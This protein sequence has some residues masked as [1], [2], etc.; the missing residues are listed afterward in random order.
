VR[1]GAAGPRGAAARHRHALA[2]G[3]KLLWYH[4]ERVLGHGAFG[5]TYLAQDENLHRPVAIKEF[6]PGQLA[7][8]EDDGS[9]QPLSEEFADDY[10]AGLASF[11]SEA[12]TLAQLEHPSIVRVHNVFEANETAYLVMQYEDGE[13]LDRIL[14]RKRTLDETEI[15]RLLGPLLAGLEYMHARGFVHRDIKPANVFIRRDG[16]PVLLDFGSARQAVS[17]EAR[18][19]TNFVSPGYAPIE[20]YAGKSDQQGPWSDIY[21]LGATL[22]RA[23]TG[24][25][26]PDAVSRSHA[27]AEDTSDSYT[28]TTNRVEGTYSPALLHAVDRALQFRVQDRPQDIGVWRQELPPLTQ[29]PADLAVRVIEDQPT[30]VL[31]RRAGA[32]PQT[33]EVVAPFGVRA[34]TLWLGGALAASVAFAILAGRTPAPEPAAPAVVVTPAVPPTPTVEA[35]ASTAPA[36]ATPP[37]GQAA[38]AAPAEPQTIPSPPDPL[39]ERNARIATLLSDARADLDAQRLTTPAGQNAYEKYRAVLSLEANNAEATHGIVAL[40]DRYLALG[41]RELGRGDLKRAE[42]YLAKAE[43]LTPKRPAIATAREL[44]AM[45]RQELAK[46]QASRPVTSAPSPAVAEQPRQDEQKAPGFFESLGRFFNGEPRPAPAPVEDRSEQ[47]RQ[48]LGGH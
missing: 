45:R 47:F 41:D 27:I 16:S 40:S 14:K 20:Q 17:G 24:H 31:P 10:R 29:D 44:L 9:V 35:T 6:L 2:P 37:A 18:T 1:D 23:M 4:L 5:I 34:R 25:A 3:T 42:A 39:A 33:G 12:R 28:S 11:I 36:P 15:L 8:R 46:K 22:Y 30:M 26:P 32:E 13:G 48:K 38:P 19:L 21:G 7:M 43:S